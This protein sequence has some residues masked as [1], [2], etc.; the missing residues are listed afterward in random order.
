MKA[1]KTVSNQ[2][3]VSPCSAAARCCAGLRRQHCPALTPRPDAPS[4]RGRSTRPQFLPLWLLALT[5]TLAG[6]FGSAPAQASSFSGSGTTFTVGLGNNQT[7]TVTAQATTYTFTSGSWT[8]TPNAN[9][10]VSGTTL[11]ITAAGRAAYDTFNITNSTANG[12]VFFADSGA[13][14]Y[15]DNF[16]VT[17]DNGFAGAVTFNGTSSFSGANAINVTNAAN[18]VFSSGASLSTV[19]GNLTLAANTQ[20]TPPPRGELFFRRGCEQ[21]HRGGH[22]HRGGYGPRPGVRD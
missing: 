11:T 13:N 20:A 19:N 14:T 5:M 18:I 17:L 15:D 9:A 10:T 21:R 2:H 16:N 12:T 7:V 4:T 3:I 8:G 22:R 6:L 1:V